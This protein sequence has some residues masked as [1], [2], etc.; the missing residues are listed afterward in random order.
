MLL[1]L[2]GR[3]EDENDG[4]SDRQKVRERERRSEIERL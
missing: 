1:N 2:H 4:E 3:C